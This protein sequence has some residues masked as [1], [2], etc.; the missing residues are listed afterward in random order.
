MKINACVQSGRGRHNV[1]LS[2]NEN[3]HSITIAPKP[4]GQG[5]SASGGELLLLAVATC[6]CNDL[7]REAG[8]RGMKL[9][10]VEVEAEGEFPEEGA[11]GRNIT[12]RARV[13]AEASLAEINALIAHTDEVAEIHNTLRTAIPVTLSKFESLPWGEDPETLS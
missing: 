1:V 8:K 5:S 7:Y 13:E 2:T 4:N 12:Y 10:Q 3:P 9:T 6:Y 11:A